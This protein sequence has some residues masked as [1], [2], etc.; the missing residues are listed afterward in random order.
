[1]VLVITVPAV[2]ASFASS[3]A[4]V[5]SRPLATAVNFAADIDQSAKALL[6][7]SWV[8]TWVAPRASSMC[9][10]ISECGW[11]R[12]MTAYADIAGSKQML[13]SNDETAEAV[14]A[15][16]SKVLIGDTDRTQKECS[17]LLHT[18]ATIVETD[19]SQIPYKLDVNV[20]GYPVWL[21]AQDVKQ[22]PTEDLEKARSS[23]ENGGK[24]SSEE[25]LALETYAVRLSLLLG[26][27][28]TESGL[29]QCWRRSAVGGNVVTSSTAT[30]ELKPVTLSFGD[31]LSSRAVRKEAKHEQSQLIQ[32][33]RHFRLNAA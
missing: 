18:I 24:A 7:D 23:A 3:M 21:R 10:S 25:R 32:S 31:H 20:N 14:L 1:M 9:T 16:G 5:E 19:S 30:R 8:D 6:A 15:V 11:N 26:Q 28:C 17:Q 4:T 29:R 13:F 22:A 27:S 2:E 33:L 12:S